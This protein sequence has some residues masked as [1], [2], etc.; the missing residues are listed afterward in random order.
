MDRRFG[1]FLVDGL[2]WTGLD[3]YV[4]GRLVYIYQIRQVGRFNLILKNSSSER[5]VIPGPLKTSSFTASDVLNLPSPG[6]Q[7]GWSWKFIQ[8]DRWV[9]GAE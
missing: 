7:A 6:I 3:V 1:M 5:S 8:Q 2:E 9:G 4:P